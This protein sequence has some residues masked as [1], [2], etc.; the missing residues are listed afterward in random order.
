MLTV[1]DVNFISPAIITKPIDESL[2]VWDNIRFFDNDGFQLNK[3][4]QEYYKANG[5]ELGYVNNYWG[6]RYDW[7]V[8]DSPKFIIDH[9]M[10][11]TR[12]KYEGEALAQIE[13]HMADHPY[14]KKF[15]K[16][17]PKWGIDFALEHIDG[18]DFME[19]IHLE[20]D[21]AR[22][23]IALETKAAYQQ[24]ILQTDWN[25]FAQQLIRH[26]D[27]WIFLEGMDRNDWKAKFWG[28]TKAES[29]LKVV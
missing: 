25:H 7:I 5:I 22:L 1:K 2:L 8:I 16:I 23:D 15:T 19:V 12:C 29:I 6:A 28:V 24:K 4:E 26:K 10:L 21:F 27:E 14:L 17:R 9:S 18:D 3:L 11:A 13:R 20:Y